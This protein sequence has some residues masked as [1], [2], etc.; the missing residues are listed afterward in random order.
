L[1]L[2]RAARSCSRN[3]L[4]LLLQSLPFGFARLRGFAGRDEDRD[5]FIR[6]LNQRTSLLDS[7]EV[8]LPCEGTRLPQ[9]LRP[10]RNRQSQFRLI[11]NRQ[12][13]IVNGESPIANRQSV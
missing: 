5:E 10:N 12:S 9:F 1:G 4:C 13:S 7:H 3:S 8:R 11:V 2:L 6:F